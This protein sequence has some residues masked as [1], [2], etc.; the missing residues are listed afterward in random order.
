MQL[1]I[2][3]SEVLVYIQ[4]KCNVRSEFSYAIFH[5]KQYI[6]FGGIILIIQNVSGITMNVFVGSLSRCVV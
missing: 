2:I 6:I 4:L 3:P 5:I 1:Q